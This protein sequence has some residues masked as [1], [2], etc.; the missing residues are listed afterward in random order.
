MEGA[1]LVILVFGLGNFIG[2]CLGG[3]GSSYLYAHFG[4]KYPAILAGSA[5]IAGCFPLWGLIN[6]NFKSNATG[7]ENGSND[8]TNFFFIGLISI[9]AGILSGITGPI[10]KST[11]QNVTMPQMRGQAFALLNT[12]DDFGRGLGPAFVA[13]MIEKMGGRRNAFNVGIF[14]WIFC[15]V[16]NGLLFW[17]VEVD[18]EKVRLGVDQLSSAGSNENASDSDRNSVDVL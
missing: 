16:L 14:G 7:D 12:F 9:L 10:V 11:L 17:T 18:E 15:G 2:T 5:A 3:L 6:F 8:S 1:T 13:W 4:S